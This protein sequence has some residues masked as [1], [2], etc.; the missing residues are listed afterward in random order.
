MI[1]DHNNDDNS[2]NDNTTTTNNNNND[3]DG[4]DD[5]LGRFQPMASKFP[6]RYL[7]MVLV[8]HLR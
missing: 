7:A 5:S 8:L 4:D 6:E 2:I 1:S 3:D